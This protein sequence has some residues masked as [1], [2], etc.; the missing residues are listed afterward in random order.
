VVVGAP[1][2]NALGVTAPAVW[3]LQVAALCHAR[4]I[5]F[6]DV[7]STLTD[8]GSG[9]SGAGRYKT[10][11]NV[12]NTHPSEIGAKAWAQAIVN[13]IASWSPFYADPL[14]AAH[15]SYS[16]DATGSFPLNA[17]NAVLL[18]D[19]NADGIPDN[20]TKSQGNAGDTISLVTETGVPGK[21][22]SIT[23][24]AN[25]TVDPILLSSSGALVPGHR[26]RA[27]LRL[28]TTGVDAAYLAQI[29]TTGTGGGNTTS[30]WAGFDVRLTDSP[31]RAG[32]ALFSLTNWKREVPLSTF[33]ADF[34]AP[35]GLPSNTTVWCIQ[36]RGSAASPAYTVEI[37]PW[38]V[39]LTTAGA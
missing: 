20:W 23:R 22:L 1:P 11:L 17:S 12:D 4:G 7:Y 30:S 2:D 38:L 29:V 27:F 39:D 5:P 13:A 10:T 28:K 15:N 37:Q 26:Y 25:G 32:N 34:V 33:S 21:M 19:T 35:A 16:S 36:L 24:A 3:N 14:A 31:A 9:I 6:V 8:D 18:T